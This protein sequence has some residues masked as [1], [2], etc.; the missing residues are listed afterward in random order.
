ML[1]CSKVVFIIFCL[2]F[3]CLNQI[4]E[5]ICS[6]AVAPRPSVHY[7]RSDDQIISLID[8][9]GIKDQRKWTKSQR[10]KNERSNSSNV[11]DFFI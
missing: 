3:L 4:E 2:F 5:Y 8:E 1:G 11:S 10:V 9:G 7:T 6:Q